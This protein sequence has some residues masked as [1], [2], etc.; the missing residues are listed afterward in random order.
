LAAKAAGNKR[1]EGI[2]GQRWLLAFDGGDERQQQRWQ[3][4]IEIALNG[5]DNGQR[6]GGGE[7]TVQW[8]TTAVAAATTMTGQRQ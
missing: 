7:T 1:N 2:D 5:G 6:Q 3:W 8:T 4:R